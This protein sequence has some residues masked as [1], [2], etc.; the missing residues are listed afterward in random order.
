MVEEKQMKR[1]IAYLHYVLLH[2]WYVFQA[3]LK[4]GIPMRRAV[5]HDWTKFL[6]GE[7]F[8]YAH[9]FFNPDGSRRNVRDKSGAYDPNS[10]PLDFQ[11][12]W[13]FHQRNPH[14]WQAWI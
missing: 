13:I 1:Q 6:P 9:Q 7:W 2:K 14:H 10:Q 3:G 11:R 8:P 12:A 5:I 4:M